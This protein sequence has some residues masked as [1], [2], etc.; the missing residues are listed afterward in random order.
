MRTKAA[1][2]ASRS[3]QAADP[4]TM[5][6]TCQRRE[7]SRDIAAGAAAARRHPRWPGCVCIEWRLERRCHL[8]APYIPTTDAG[9]DAW[10]NNFADLIT[11]D[12]ALYG[13]TPADAL[14]IQTAVDAWNVSYPLAT[15]PA[16]RTT[17]TISQKNADKVAMVTICR[18]YASQVRINPGVA[19]EDKLALGLNLP[20]NSPSPIPTPPTFPL[21]DIANAGPLIHVLRYADNTT[22]DSRRKPDGAVSLELWGV[23]AEAA[24]T[25]PAL[26]QK[27]LSVTKQ[28]TNVT[29]PNEDL[30]KVASYIGRWINRKGEAGPWSAPINFVIAG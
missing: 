6:K 15:N 19:N 9:L 7:M 26:M 14:A 12:P 13:L 17:V 11:A 30:G 18:T 28:P 22:P 8:T 21:L 27:I 29:W 1:A 2:E 10:A 20:N 23:A 5:G 3:E 24:V 16:T 25:D 4:I